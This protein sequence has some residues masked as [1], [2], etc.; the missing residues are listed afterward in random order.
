MPSTSL[1]CLESYLFF[2]DLISQM[3]PSSCI[4]RSFSIS[5]W[6]W[7]SIL[8]KLA[9]QTDPPKMDG[10]KWKID[11]PFQ[12]G[13]PC[14]NFLQIQVFLAPGIF[15]HTVGRN[16]LNIFQQRS[17]TMQ[18][19]W[20]GILVKFVVFFAS[21]LTGENQSSSLGWVVGCTTIDPRVMIQNVIVYSILLY[22]SLWFLC[23][24][25]SF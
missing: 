8:E 19:F 16:D 14:C 11:R 22:I 18:R 4:I 6:S 2:T 3:S 10:Q 20:G 25:I 7:F 13:F 23:P 9:N 12:K 17:A 15:S 24:I 21:H 5:D 1:N